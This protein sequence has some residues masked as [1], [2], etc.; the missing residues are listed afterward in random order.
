MW[1][2]RGPNARLGVVLGRATRSCA[3]HITG[4]TCEGAAVSSGAFDCPEIY[5]AA[6][7]ATR[8]LWSPHVH[9]RPRRSRPGPFGEQGRGERTARLRQTISKY[10]KLIGVI[11]LY[12]VYYSCIYLYMCLNFEYR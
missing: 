5:C 10:I 12:I 8:C 2:P 9:P 11:T 7:A 4:I 6:V 1:S 3:N